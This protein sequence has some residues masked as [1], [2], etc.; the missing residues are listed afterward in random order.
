MPIKAP[1]HFGFELPLNYCPQSLGQGNSDLD[2]K[3][4]GSSPATYTVPTEMP[5]GLKSVKVH[6]R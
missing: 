5:T 4:V 3:N 6:S 1:Q 2:P